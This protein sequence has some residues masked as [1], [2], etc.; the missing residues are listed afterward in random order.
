MRIFLDANILFSAAKSAG[1]VRQLVERARSA[2]HRCADAYL[3]A[4]ARRNL[5]V[6]EAPSLAA[7]EDLLG[8]VELSRLTS[9]A[10][11]PEVTV[12]LPE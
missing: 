1:A 12:L 5:A 10:L 6:K 11:P 8:G 4:E 9:G 3:V 7:L 2:G